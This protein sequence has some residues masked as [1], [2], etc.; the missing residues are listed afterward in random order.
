VLRHLRDSP[1]RDAIDWARVDL[2]WG[3]DRFVAGDSADRNERQAREALLDGLPLAADRV[4]AMAAA[5]GAYGADP[6]AAAAAYAETLARAA[7]P[8]DHGPVP[9]FDVCL[10]GIGEEG[11]VASIFPGSPAVYETERTVVAVR[12]CPKP[13][14][15]RISLTLPAIRRAREV[16]LLTTGAAK[17]AAVAMALGGAGEVAVPAAG[18]RGRSRTLWLLDRAAA[19][20]VPQQFIPPIA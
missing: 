15:T 4:H 8:E 10:L 13:P 11:H 7:R 20:K 17:A 14:P 1:A 2:Y 9:T 16:W 6:D 19:A 5:D 12:N 3:D 18:A